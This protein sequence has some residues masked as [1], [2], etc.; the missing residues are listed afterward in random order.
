MSGTEISRSYGIS[1][2]TAVV[3]DMSPFFFFFSSRRRHTIFDCD[4]SS[5]VCSSDL[6]KLLMAI[7]EDMAC[8]RAVTIVPQNAEVTTQQA[9]DFLN[10]SRPFLVT[11][12][13]QKKLPFRDRKSVV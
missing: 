13:E 6:A 8:G 5:D 7:L 11:L 12:L 10:V 4:W 9:A 2:G 3:W 1:F